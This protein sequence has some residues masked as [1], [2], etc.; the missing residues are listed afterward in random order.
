MVIRRALPGGTGTSHLLV[1]LP[2]SVPFDSVVAAR[3]RVAGLQVEA[4]RSKDASTVRDDAIS[5]SDHL[6]DP[7]RCNTLDDILEISYLTQ[8]RCR[9]VVF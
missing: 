9:R 1:V 6:R 2:A 8:P 4:K 3:F 7:S 5:S